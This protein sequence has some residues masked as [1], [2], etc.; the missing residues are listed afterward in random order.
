GLYGYSPSLVSHA[1]CGGYSSAYEAA[2]DMLKS[3]RL[4]A[5]DEQDVIQEKERVYAPLKSKGDYSW[6][7]YEDTIRQV[8]N[9]Y[10]GHVRNQ[11]G[12]ELALKKLKKIEKQSGDMKAGNIHELLRVNEA[13][14]LVRYCQLMVKSALE[15][16]ESGRGCYRRTDYPQLDPSLND[17]EIVQWQVNGKPK[18]DKITMR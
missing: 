8:M 12:M 11:Q 3:A 7:E 2:Q 9:Y 10:M 14:H 13:M 16:K 1:M 6:R 15:R 17:K 18:I 4:P 5:L